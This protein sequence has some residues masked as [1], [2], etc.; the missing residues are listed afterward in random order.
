MSNNFMTDIIREKI[1]NTSVNTLELDTLFLNH[2]F[3][4]GEYFRLRKKDTI[5]PYNSDDQFGLYRYNSVDFCNNC[6]NRLK[7]VNKDGQHF[8][9]VC[10]IKYDTKYE[11]NPITSTTKSSYQPTVTYDK[12]S[13]FMEYVDIMVGTRKDISLPLRYQNELRARFRGK[14]NVSP[15]D[16]YAFMKSYDIFNIYKNS[17]G[18]IHFIATG[19]KYI[20][21][22]DIDRKRIGQIYEKFLFISLTNSIPLPIHKSMFSRLL[23]LMKIKVNKLKLCN[24]KGFTNGNR[25]STNFNKIY[26]IYKQKEAL[27]KISYPTNKTKLGSSLKHHTRNFKSRSKHEYFR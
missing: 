24:I 13:K 21:L 9:S 6:T 8:C 17:I 23:A 19:K 4:V 20:N 2:Q 22:S 27:T 14:K 16:L 11:T 3:D 1:I 12:V 18:T 26:D 10:G 5:V 25:M 15:N 7:L